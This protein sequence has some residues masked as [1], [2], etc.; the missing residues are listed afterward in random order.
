MCDN[1]S[2]NYVWKYIHVRNM[3]N[4]V[5]IIRV[6]IEG[7]RTKSVISIKLFYN[8]YYFANLNDNILNL[9]ND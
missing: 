3:R 1:Y 4:I 6:V 7:F 9:I 8:I 5:F 2:T